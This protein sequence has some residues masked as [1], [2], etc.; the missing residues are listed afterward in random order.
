MKELFL[1]VGSPHQ[2]PIDVLYAIAKVSDSE[3]P[4]APMCMSGWQNDSISDLETWNPINEFPTGFAA[5]W[6]SLTERK[7]YEIDVDFSDVMMENVAK[8]TKKGFKNK[9]GEKVNYTHFK[10]SFFPGGLVRFHLLSCSKI[11]SLDY[12]FRGKA[13]SEFNDAFLQQF[14]ENSKVRT[15]DDYYNIYYVSDDNDE[16][17]VILRKKAEFVNDI[18]LPN[19]T[20]EKYYTRYNY[21]IRFVFENPFCSLYAWTPKFTNGESYSCQSEVNEDVVIKNPSTICSLN[22]WWRS[23]WD[24]Y[25]SYLYFDEDEILSLFERT[26]SSQPD[27]KGEL[28]IT[29]CKYDN[30]MEIVFRIGDDYY[31]LRNIEIR[32]FYNFLFELSDDGQLKYK[33]YEGDHKNTFNCL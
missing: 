17:S 19:K 21:N 26:F 14:G 4:Y 31:P 18:A 33:N 5:V 27:Q 7:I 24:Q 6:M 25:T 29:V 13:T 32:T 3:N 30:K 28:V 1:G 12:Q 15:I 20:W 11:T 9:R 16:S 8:I 22:L 10:A 23:N 2:A